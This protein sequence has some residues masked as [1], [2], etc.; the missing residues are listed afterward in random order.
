[1]S[2]GGGGGTQTTQTS[3]D[4]PAWYQQAQQ[5]NIARA[6]QLANRDYELYEA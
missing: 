5:G 3:V 1:M 2:F 4:V 6:G